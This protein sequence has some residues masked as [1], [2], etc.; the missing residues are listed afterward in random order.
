MIWPVFGNS[1]YTTV[2]DLRGEHENR[3]LDEPSIVE[4]LGMVYEHMPIVS[5]H[6]IGFESAAKLDRLI[7]ESRG[8]VLVHCTSSNRVGAL[9]ALRKSLAGADNESAMKHGVDGGLT[10][11]AG[12]VQEVLNSR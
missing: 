8:P 1:G 9:L 5:A 11:L 3:G 12:T 6:D 10:D 4:D 7:E 2:I